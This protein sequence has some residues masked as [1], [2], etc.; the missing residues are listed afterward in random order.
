MISVNLLKNIS[1]WDFE[2]L[3]LYEFN[4]KHDYLGESS[5]AFNWDP[6]WGNV[7]EIWVF[8]F[9]LDIIVN[10]VAF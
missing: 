10:Q 8:G 2:A 6:S 5:S 1:I 4:P 3:A 9:N 7:H